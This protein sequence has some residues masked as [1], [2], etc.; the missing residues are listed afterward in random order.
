MAD[1]I[2]IG[3]GVAGL[4]AARVLSQEGL[5]VALLEARDRLGGR[6]FTHHDTTPVE[7][8]AEFIHGKPEVTFEIVRAGGIKAIE[9]RG[10]LWLARDG[11][12]SP[13]SGW[14]SGDDELWSALSEW[15]GDDQTFDQFI[16]QRFPDKEHAEIRQT[17]AGYIEGYEAA[18][19]DRVS[20]AWFVKTEA[21]QAAINGDHNFRI[22]TGYD[23]V[24][25]QMAAQFASGC[26]SI[27]LNTT[28]SEIRW[29]PK[30]VEVIAHS[31]GEATTFTASRAVITLPLG[32]LKN[33]FRF[34]PHLPEKQVAMEQ[35]E[36]GAVIKPVLRF[37]ER[38]WD[39]TMGFLFSDDEW[40]PT[41]WTQ[42]P[43]D[44]PLLTGWVGGPRAE[45]LSHQGKAFVID[46]ALDALSHIFS[47]TRPQ[48]EGLLEA[49]YMHDWQA[50]PF[51]RGA[52]SYV[53]VGG[54]DAPEKLAQPVEDTLYFAGEATDTLGYT[55]TVHGAIITGQRAAEAILTN[56]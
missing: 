47:M 39:K 15:H 53:A 35:I 34:S 52:Y 4:T 49:S 10:N 43:N 44:V 32:V 2:V 42:Y 7:L 8:G 56:A 45:R 17:A 5:T 26:V 37:R 36:M 6:I 22:S 21:A 55:G 27:H 3:A 18:R 13:A 9:M 25:Q 41:W 38:F 50:D 19:T 14:D 29:K 30:H 24:S 40:I 54:I 23:S 51:S 48:L 12:L 11:E 16:N 46:R 20:M 31:P 33:G 28:V 1:V